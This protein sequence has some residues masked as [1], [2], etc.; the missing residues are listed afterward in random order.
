M[1]DSK[2]EKQTQNLRFKVVV[3]VAVV[4]VVVAVVD[5]DDDNYDDDDDDH[6]HDDDD[7]VTLPTMFTENCTKLNIFKLVN[8]LSTNAIVNTIL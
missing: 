5:D 8:Y 2:Q 7:D 1:R 6:N 3:A 4:V